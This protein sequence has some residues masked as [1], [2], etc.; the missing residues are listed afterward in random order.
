MGKLTVNNK[1]YDTPAPNITLREVKELA[2]IPKNNK[3]YNK[4]GD[5]LEDSDVLELNDE[6][7]VELGNINS[8]TRGFK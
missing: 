8:W 2:Q 3:V 5:I 6:K 7:P 4:N 1:L